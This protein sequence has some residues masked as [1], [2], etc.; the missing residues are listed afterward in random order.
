MTDRSIEY[1]PLADLSTRRAPGNPKDH[2]AAVIERSVSR[3]G[4]VEPIVLDERTGK[5]VAGHGRLDDIEARVNAGE[6]IPDGLREENGN[7]LVPVIRGWASKDDA[8]ANAYLIVSNQATIAGGWDEQALA[9]L[10]SGL[11]ASGDAEVFA[12]SGFTTGGLDELL[13]SIAGFPVMSEDPTIPSVQALRIA[14]L[15]PHPRNYQTHTETQI[16][17]L[18][19]AISQ[20]AFYKNI[21]VARDYT[22][23]AGHGAVLAATSLGM[24]TVPGVRL[25][26]DPDSPQA[27]KIVAADNEIMKITARD[28]RDLSELLREVRDSDALNLVGTGYDEMM[29]ANLLMVTRPSGEIE[30]FNAA[31]EWIGLPD[32]EAKMPMIRFIINFETKE[33]R[34]LYL[35]E[36]SGH[37]SKRTSIWSWSGHWPKREE[38]RESQDLQWVTPEEPGAET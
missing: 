20:H 32:Y 16:E 2:D 35:K 3:F 1:M 14:D 27:L 15:H 6:A 8:E 18:A 21:V 9:D 33:D 38:P 10:L 5:L 34:D 22:I 19:A 28:D 29:L 23:L 7:W 25:D 12:A 30:D 4:F 24:K 11:V 37:V 36:F 31:A 17:H 13:A 26:L